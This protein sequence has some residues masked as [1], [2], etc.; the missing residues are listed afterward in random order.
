VDARG[1]DLWLPRKLERHRREF[2]ERP[3]T[4]LTFSW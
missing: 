2:E 3:E 1:D 4:D